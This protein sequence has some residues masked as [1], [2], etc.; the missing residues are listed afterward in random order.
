VRPRKQVGPTCWYTTSH[1]STYPA[2]TCHAPIGYAFTHRTPVHWDH[3]SPVRGPCYT[4]H[5]APSLRVDWWCAPGPCVGWGCTG[6]PCAGNW[7]ALGRRCRAGNSGDLHRG[8]AGGEAV[9]GSVALIDATV[10]STSVVVVVVGVVD[11]TVSGVSMGTVV[12]V[13]TIDPSR[14]PG[15]PLLC[16]LCQGCPANCGPSPARPAGESTACMSVA[17]G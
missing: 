6:G 16:V 17:K 11:V 14:L 7:C 4:W 3:C 10:V 5:C 2:P 1:A 12:G 9:D 8:N 15:L 13:G